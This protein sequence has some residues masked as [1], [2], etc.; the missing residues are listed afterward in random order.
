MRALCPSVFVSLPISV[1]GQDNWL[2]RHLD[3]CCAIR[4]HL[5]FFFCHCLYSPL[6]PW[7]LLFSFMIIFTD[8]RT[9][10]ASDQLVAR[11]LPKHRTTQTQNKHIHQTSM[12]YVGFEPTIP[13]SERAKTVHALDRSPTV[14]GHLIIVLINIL[15]T[16]I[17]TWRTWTCEVRAAVIPFNLGIWNDVW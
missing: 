4:G 5:I 2:R 14:T 16:V 12:S 17:I 6:G 15:Q 8:G 13:A 7:P 1:F 9:P 11:P 3:E 10:W